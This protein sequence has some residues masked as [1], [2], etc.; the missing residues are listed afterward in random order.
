MGG[1]WRMTC[2]E[3]ARTLLLAGA[4]AA[5]VLAGC[6]RGAPSTVVVVEPV[7]IPLGPP[8]DSI[9][10]EISGLAWG[11]DTLYFLPQFPERFGEGEGNLVF[12]GV[13]RE[14]LEARLDGTVTAPLDYLEIPCNAPWLAPLIEGFDGL[15]SVGVLGRRCFMT[16]EAEGD[17]TASSFLAAGRWEDSGGSLTLELDR[18]TSIPMDVKLPNV[19]VETIVMDGERIVT[20]GE[21]NGLNINP[22]PR[23]LVFDLELNEVGTMP[24]PQ[25]EYRITDATALDENRRFWVLNYAYP[26]E[27]AVLLPAVDPETERFGAPEWLTGEVCVERLLELRI[28]DDERIVRTD[29]PPLW[30]QPREDGRCRNWEAMVR[31]GDRGFLLMTD[32]HPETMLAFVPLPAGLVRP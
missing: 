31:Y 10:A 1:W 17:S 30:L 5:L 13:P 12:F 28:T 19:S 20:I 15:E 24:L 23:A 9:D 26:P 16:I 18:L 29:T 4:C 25:I 6:D 22:A 2:S 11:A 21:A 14:D 27:C 7:P 32:E 3:R 8:L